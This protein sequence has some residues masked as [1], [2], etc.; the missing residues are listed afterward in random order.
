MLVEDAL[1]NAAAR[2]TIFA[3]IVSFMNGR[4]GVRSEVLTFLS[5]L[6]NAGVTPL[7]PQ[8]G[9]DGPAVAKAVLGGGSCL[10]RGEVR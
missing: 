8:Q 6:L 2:S 1:S 4:A 10:F 3:R 5:G 9:G 7:L